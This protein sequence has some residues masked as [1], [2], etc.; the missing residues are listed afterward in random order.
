MAESCSKTIKSVLQGPKKVSMQGVQ[1]QNGQKQGFFI[2]GVSV[3]MGWN[4]VFSA[5]KKGTW[6]KMC[7]NVAES[8]SKNNQKFPY[9]VFKVKMDKK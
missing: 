8:C 5:L 4:N 2:Q 1:S 3:K 7:Q 9:R 6:C